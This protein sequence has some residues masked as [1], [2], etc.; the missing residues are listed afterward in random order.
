V[1]QLQGPT[2]LGRDGRTGPMA[3]ATEN[4]IVSHPIVFGML[5]S[6]PITAVVIVV[7]IWFPRMGDAVVRHILL[8]RD[9]CLTILLFYSWLH[10]L[11]SSHKRRMFWPSF[12]V[13]FLFHTTFVTFVTLG[14][15]PLSIWEWMLLGVVESY[16]VVGLIYRPLQG[17]SPSPT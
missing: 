9:I 3:G 6:V 8:E 13:L 17:S 12:F 4:K 1:E 11:W 7:G 15:R 16:L 14:F 2:S 5:L 10:R